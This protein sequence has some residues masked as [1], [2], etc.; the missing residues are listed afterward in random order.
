MQFETPE[1]KDG[2]GVEIYVEPNLIE[3]FVNEGEY[4][5]TN[6]V[7]DLGDKIEASCVDGV[8]MYTV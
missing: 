4:V 1:L 3:V 7:Y 8:K 5:I 2:C 6:V